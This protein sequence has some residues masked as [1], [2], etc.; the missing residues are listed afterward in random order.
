MD[1]RMGGGRLASVTSSTNG[2]VQSDHD[3]KNIWI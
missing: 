1:E 2:L 3:T